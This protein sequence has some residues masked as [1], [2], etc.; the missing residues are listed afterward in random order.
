MWNQETFVQ[1]FIFAGKQDGKIL[2][3]RELNP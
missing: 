3:I 1:S 2:K